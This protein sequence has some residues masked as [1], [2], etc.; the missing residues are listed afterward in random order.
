MDDDD[1]AAL[2]PALDRIGRADLVVGIFSFNSARAIGHVVEAAVAGVS[3]YYPGTSCVIVNADGGSS[4]GTPEVAR[5]AARD[6]CPV[7]A[8]GDSLPPSY[9]LA[10]GYAGFPG[11]AGSLRAVL[12]VA[13]RLEARAC[14]LVDGDVRAMA[15]EWVQCLADPVLR[16]G[17]DFVAP[18]YAG[19]RYEG[20]LTSTLIYPLT[21][22]LYGR[23][24]RQPVG[25]HFGLSGA[26]AARLLRCGVWKRD[27]PPLLDLWM[28]TTA[29]ADGRRVCQAHLGAGRGGSRR[30]AAGLV[31]A[32]TGVVG[33]A[34]MLMGARR[35]VWWAVAATDDVP[36]YGRSHGMGLDPV[37][38]NVD[39]M[40]STFRQ[41]VSELMPVW[42]RAL[43][44]ETCG[45]LAALEEE[46]TPEF[47]FPPDLWA[48]AVY[49]CAA[50]AHRRALPFRHVL[51]AMIPLYLGRAA[52]F[53]LRTE[54]GGEADV[55]AEIEEGC[56]AFESLKPHLLRRWDAPR[57]QPTGRS[58]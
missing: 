37:S 23:R 15:A 35:P 55:E 24:L 36:T 9:A 39:R 11:P 50:A 26:Q 32:M 54:A 43:D 17:M 14:L 47:R 25:G 1:T 58:E 52:D 22:A 44:P 19:H 7:L 3:A 45:A 21:R 38:V 33:T 28:A 30:A 2:S 16:D 27:A 8:V 49:D 34:F 46:G 57:P 48:R 56:R 12:Q 18:V 10:G 53:V 6:R 13:E 51:G 42:R 31:A 20:M 41:G 4:D 5:R 40:V 29:I